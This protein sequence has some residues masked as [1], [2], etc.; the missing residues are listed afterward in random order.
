M[1]LNQLTSDSLKMWVHLCLLAYKGCSIPVTWPENGAQV[2][3]WQVW[4]AC[5]HD[6][7]V[8]SICW[9]GYG[10]EMFCQMILSWA[11]QRVGAR[12]ERLLHFFLS[13][14]YSKLLLFFIRIQRLMC[15]PVQAQTDFD[16]E[17]ILLNKTSDLFSF[18]GLRRVLSCSIAL[19]LCIKACSFFPLRLHLSCWCSVLCFPIFHTVTLL[20]QTA[21]FLYLKAAYGGPDNH[22]T[23][24]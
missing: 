5:F 2:T 14:S 10:A 4:L 11:A 7:T 16:M 8:D 22:E 3:W 1:K 18:T 9:V 24:Y 12:M 21:H 23:C 15:S 6:N 13:S 20:F 19:V 17:K